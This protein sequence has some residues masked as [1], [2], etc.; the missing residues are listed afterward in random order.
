MNNHQIAEIFEDVAGLLEMK[1]EQVF[2]V[3]A[4]QRAARTIGRLPAELDQMVAEGRDLTEITG[5]GQAIAK[6]ITELVDTG[7]LEYY[8]KLRAEFPNGILDVM[9]VPGVGPKTTKLLW[10]GVGVETVDQLEKAIQDGRVAA[11]PRMGPRKADAILREIEGSRSSGERVP[12]A[13]ALSAARRVVAA[14]K[15]AAPGIRR[16]EVAGSLRRFEETIGNIDLVCSAHDPLQVLEAFAQLPDV[17]RVLDQGT[18]KASVVLTD[19]VQVDLHVT[20][21]RRYGSAL[22]YFTGSKQHNEML[23]E[24]ASQLGLSLT[25][26][27]VTSLETGEIEEFGDEPALYDRLGLQYIPPELRMGVIEVDAAQQG[28]VPSLVEVA[29]LRGD[30]HLHT[31]WSDGED[32]VD[33]MVAAAKAKGYEYLAVT[34]HSVGLGIANGLSEE[35]LKLHRAMLRAAEKRVGGIRVLQGSEVDIRADGSLDYPDE[36][37]ERL[38][39]VVASIHSAMNQD[40]AV[41][42]E[43]I[44]KAMRNPHVSAIGHLSARRIGERRPVDADFDA[45][46][47]AAADTGTALEINSSPHRLDIKDAHVFKA[48]RRGVRLVIDSDAHTVGELDQRTN[49]VAV[50]RRGWCEAKDILNTLPLEQ[51]LAFLETDKQLRSKVPSAHG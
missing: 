5:I 44:V 46:I 12:I 34:D 47:E 8:E 23:G 24:H 7:N 4:Y 39:W 31:N 42:T 37:L 10:E 40:S 18:T 20:E 51:F 27:G 2:T 30:L 43:R 6:K 38:D 19:G 28:A 33:A 1:A 35:R 3:R 14:L 25:A 36:V 45:I 13:R 50:A 9:R 21:D 15:E 16:L 11:L 29:D 17:D 32:D 48:R 49:G 41:M 26:H 22:Q